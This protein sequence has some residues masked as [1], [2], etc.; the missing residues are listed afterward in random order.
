MEVIA[1]HTS[2][3]NYNNHLKVLK[4]IF[5]ELEEEGIIQNTPILRVKKRKQVT[6]IH[7]VYSVEQV[8]NIIK[9]AKEKHPNLYLC[10]LLLYYQ[11]IRI[12]EITVLHWDNIDL[13]NNI[14]NIIPQN[15]KNGLLRSLPIHD[16]LI[17]VLKTRD[18]NGY[19]FDMNGKPPNSDYFGTKWGRLKKIIDIEE[20]YTLYGF[21]HTGVT[22]LYKSTKDIYLVSRLC[23]HISIKTTEIYLR[24][25]GLDINYL[26]NSKLPSI[27]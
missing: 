5:N 25:L 4:L 16:D 12:S 26:S 19:L 15:S 17:Q 3:R 14:I 1:G 2:G 13:G 22:N 8:M 20:G 6:T 7:K 11:F 24:S 18:Q 9:V 27:I 23:G 21:K 10:I